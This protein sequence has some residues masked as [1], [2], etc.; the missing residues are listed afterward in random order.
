MQ[1]SALH[2]CT[3]RIISNIYDAAFLRKQ[4][5]AN[6]VNYF[7]KNTLSYIF[8]RVLHAPLVTQIKM[9]KTHER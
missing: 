2:R 1:D 7:R 5:I 8:D 3:L 9:L 6:T 4:L